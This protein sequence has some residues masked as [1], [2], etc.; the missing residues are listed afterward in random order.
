MN[1]GRILLGVTGSIAAYKSAE[2]VRCFIRAGA[3]VKVVMTPAAG[4][5]ITPLTLATLS[6]HPVSTAY[7][8]PESGEW[9]SHVELGLWADAM[10]IAPA[11]ANT[12]AAMASGLCSN[13]LLAAYLSAR[14]PVYVAPAMDLDMYAHPATGRSLSVLQEDGVRVIQPG[15]G[16]LAS[17]LSGKGRMAEPEN[18]SKQVL[19]ALAQGLGPIQ[20]AKRTSHSPLSLEGRNA[21]VTAGPS[22]EDIDPVRYIGNRS[23]GKM[24]YAIAEALAEAGAHVTLIS[25]PTQLTP[26]HSGIRRIDVRSAQ[27]MFEAAREHFPGSDIAVLA[28][29]VADYRPAFLH[30]HKM[31]KQS[32]AMSLEL[33]RTVDIAGSLGEIREDHQF[34]VGFA[35]ETQNEEENALSKLRKKRFDMIV[36]NS[37]NTPGAGFAHDTNAVTFYFPD[38][39]MEEGKL[40]SKKEVAGDIVAQIAARIPSASENGME[41]SSSDEL[42]GRA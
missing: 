36:M 19:G 38:G 32:G 7:F 34:I 18:I 26:S 17:G 10:V 29:A 25:G 14:C 40:K 31:K 28:A 13:L 20:P 21:M 6:K 11:S 8:D 16:E 42:G 2:L 37:L 41:S 33:E 4:D 30:R 9:D 1:N 15:D 24:G 23:T 22:Y 5:F 39:S 35:L 27:Q 12:L 3:E